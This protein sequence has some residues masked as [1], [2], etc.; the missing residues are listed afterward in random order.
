MQAGGARNPKQGKGG[1]EI[2]NKANRVLEDITN[3]EENNNLAEGVAL[4]VDVAV[5][6]VLGDLIRRLSR[7]LLLK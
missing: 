1:E 6:P 4:E 3:N 5:S 7:N 2:N